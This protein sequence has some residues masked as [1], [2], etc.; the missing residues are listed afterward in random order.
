MQNLRY[1]VSTLIG[2]AAVLNAFAACAQDFPS[3]PLRII[4]G[5]AG[6]ITDLMSRMIA[7]DLRAN[8][9]QTVL[10]AVG[11]LALII[12]NPGPCCMSRSTGLAG[13]APRTRIHWGM[14]PSW[15]P[16]SVSISMCSP[17]VTVVTSQV[18]TG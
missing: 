5:T 16:S 10:V 2:F 17:S 4:T 9:G 7:Q 18:G 11:K 14:P 3:K 8:L 1:I 6:G 15:I 12:G 13:S